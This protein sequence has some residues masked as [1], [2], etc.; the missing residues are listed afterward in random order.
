MARKTRLKSLDTMFKDVLKNDK[1]LL[2]RIN[3]EEKN[4]LLF[5]NGFNECLNTLRNTG[6][7]DEEVLGAYIDELE[8]EL[9][10]CLLRV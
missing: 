1:L 8:S 2:E 5:Y 6:N 7:I 3:N 4:R 9:K 10:I